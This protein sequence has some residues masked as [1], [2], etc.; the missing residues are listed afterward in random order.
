MK[1]SISVK[2]RLLQ[3][4]SQME[5]N[6][7]SYVK[8]PGRVFSRNRKLGFSKTVFFILCME[9][10]TLKKELLK[11]FNFG[12]DAPSASAFCQQRAKIKIQAFYHIMYSLDSSFPK[13]TYKGYHI[14]ACD[15]SDISLPME[16]GKGRDYACRKRENQKEYFQMHTS[17]MYDLVNRR[18]LDIVN[19]PRKK[20]DE[21]KAFLEMLKRGDFNPGTIFVMDRGYEGYGLM[22]EVNSMGMFY[23]IRAKDGSRGGIVKSTG[24]PCEGEYDRVFSRIF[25]FRHNRTVTSHPEIYHR[26]HRSKAVTFLSN[27]HPYHRMSIRILRLM[28]SPGTYECIITN[29][30]EEQFPPEEIKKI[31]K[32]RWGIENS[33]RE[34]KYAAGVSC[35][36]SKKEE[37]IIQEI[38]ARVILYNF[39]EIITTHVTITQKKRK[40]TYQ[41]N[42]TMAIFLCRKFLRMPGGAFHTD[43]EGLISKELLPV[44]PGRSYKRNLKAHPAVSFLYRTS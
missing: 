42:Y 10:Q 28:V 16:Q 30:P 26:I 7:G 43:I 5:E 31:Y 2:K 14:V 24:I 21:R 39:C 34:L 6:G 13:K 41:V 36:H 27:G 38:L 35:L 20:Q 15:G 18:Y 4:I 33:F 11:F 32:M 44:R 17:A 23:V 25:T 37:Y 9:A 29:L 3:I 40:Y 8:N 22:G 12:A 19:E 1:F